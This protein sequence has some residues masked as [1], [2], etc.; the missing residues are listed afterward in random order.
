MTAIVITRSPDADSG[1]HGQSVHEY[2]DGTP[3]AFHTLQQVLDDPTTTIVEAE[4]NEHGVVESLGDA[5]L[6]HGRSKRFATPDQKLA[7]RVMHRSCLFP[8][9]DIPF[10][11]CEQHH[12]VEFQH[13]GNTDLI[14]LGPVCCR[15]HHQLH[16]HN[17]KLRLDPRHPG[18]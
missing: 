9:C 12:L 17:W 11:R 10:D 15:H 13:H 4:V 18:S 6:N 7:L 14:D 2:A 8:G 5:V 16:A 1:P 3:I